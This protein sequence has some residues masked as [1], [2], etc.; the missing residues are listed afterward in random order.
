MADLEFPHLFLNGSAREQDYTSPQ[1]GRDDLEVPERNDRNGQADFVK[2]GLEAAWSS[3]KESLEERKA[4]SLPTRNGTYIQFDSAIG[5]DLKTKS[6]DLKQSGIRLLNVSED[7]PDGDGENAGVITKATIYVPAGKEGILLGKIEKYRTEENAKSG[8]PRNQGLINGIENVQEAIIESFWRDPLNLIPAPDNPEWCEVWLRFSDNKNEVISSFHEVCQQLDIITKDDYLTFPERVVLIIRA[9]QQTLSEL[10]LSFDYIAEFR[11]AKET[12]DFWLGLDN[13]DQID[14]INNLVTRINVIDNNH[15][16]CVIDTGVNNGHIMLAPVLN[17]SDCH[18][19]DV[20]W[21]TADRH[22]HGT[23]MSGVVTYGGNLDWLLQSDG[24]IDIPFKLESV[25]L[26]PSPGNHHDGELYGLRTKQAISRAE[27]KN[28]DIN[29]T[30]CLAITSDDFRDKGRPSSWSGA[31]DQL[32]SGAEDD[33]PRLIILSAGNITDPQEWCNYPDTNITNLIHDPGQ[34]WNALTVGS[35][36]NKVMIENQ[37]LNQTYSPIA[38]AGQLSPFST[39][40]YLWES[41]WPNKPDIVFEGGNAGIDGTGFTTELDDLSILSTHHKPQ[42]KQLSSILATSASTAQA[43]NFA[44]KISTLYPNMWP[45]T[46]RGLLVHSA[47]WTQA[48]WNQFYIAGNS[49][50]KNIERMLRICGYGIPDFN[51]AQQCASNSLTLIAQETI[52]PFESKETGT[53]Y[54]TKDMH[55]HEL[56][57]P[58]E[59]LRDLPGETPVTINITLSY[60][61]E[62]GPGEIGWRDKYRYRSHGLHFDIKNPTEN[63]EEFILRSNRAAR[64]DPDGDYRGSS[65]PWTIGIQHGRTRGSIHRDWWQTTAAEAAACN[66]VGIFP[67]TGWWKDRNHLR[68]GST[69]TRY[70]L[71]VSITTADQDVELYAPVAVMVAPEIIT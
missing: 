61:V 58:V 32:A 57:W 42:E 51:K 67:R 71:I 38:Q 36:T 55:L 28:P 23:L 60:F 2:N 6:F 54:K 68:K 22:G 12:A 39:T 44:G 3:S 30:T 21:G 17:D 56:P 20:E 25:K 65:V 52:Q 69:E 8:N 37:E 63:V 26:I 50:K 62:P 10:M 70:S 64:D 45:E 40:S 48:I 34:A 11:R 7:A 13:A 1:S 15:S 66:V 27:I 41:K 59:A 46:I 35:V 14:W 29:R 9:T 33:R 53:E 5:F 43:A 19:V 49:E 24:P 4:V 18:S 16:I 47:N 31:I